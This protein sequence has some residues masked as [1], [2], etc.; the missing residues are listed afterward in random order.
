MLLR[1]VNRTMPN[2]LRWPIWPYNFDRAR[3][4]LQLFELWLMN[5]APSE[6]C[7]DRYTFKAE[8]YEARAI[9]NAAGRS[10]DVF[11]TFPARSALEFQY[12]EE[13][14]ENTVMARHVDLGTA[15]RLLDEWT[16]R[17]KSSGYKR[18]IL[19]SIGRRN[20]IHFENVAL[21]FD[22]PLD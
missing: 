11:E 9:F 14:A 17:A 13:L 4:D 10:Y 7:T 12:F 20:G 22:I 6:I 15:V 1:I 2:P 3:Q 19:S 16:E 5:A 18:D 8:E 21:T